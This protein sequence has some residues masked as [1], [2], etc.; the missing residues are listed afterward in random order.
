[1]A[2]ALSPSKTGARLSELRGGVAS[3]IIENRPRPSRPRSVKMNKTRY[4]VNRNASPLK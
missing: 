3:L 1:M 2:D 4:P